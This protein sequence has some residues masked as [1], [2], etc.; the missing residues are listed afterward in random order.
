VTNRSDAVA[1]PIPHAVNALWAQAES[2]RLAS[3]LRRRSIAPVVL[4]GPE[5]QSRLFD[6][7]GAYPSAD[8]DILVH[9]AEATRIDGVLTELGFS[10]HPGNDPWWRVTGHVRYVRSGFVIDVHRNLSRPAV[11]G[12]LLRPLERSLWVD[13]SDPRSGFLEPAIEPLLVLLAVD[14]ASAGWRRPGDLAAIDAAASAVRDWDRVWRIATDCRVVRCLRT[15]LSGGRDDVDRVL[16]GTIGSVVATFGQAMNE[17]APSVAA[18]DLIREYVSYRR[19]GIRLLAPSKI[20]PRVYGHRMEIWEGVCGPG[21]WSR[22]LVD[23]WTGAADGRARPVLVEIGTGSGSLAILAARRRPDADIHATDISFRAWRNARAN[24]RRHGAEVTVH[25]GSL[26][27]ALP[28]RLRHRVQGVVA[29]LPSVWLGGVDEY[30]PD[31]I[32]APRETYEGSGGDGLDLFREL[33]RQAPRWLAAAG[34]VVISMESWQWQVFE[35]EVEPLGYEV[36]SLFRPTESGR[37]IVLRR[38]IPAA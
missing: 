29:H 37:V 20:R 22:T 32:R 21:T 8:T 1:H 38:S 31:E 34:Q 15:G 3:E 35:T 11:P 19:H 26:F 17:S 6:N 23:A 27:D 13:A 4:R 18:Q 36:I 10:F 7:P 25:R 5:L 24:V 12:F 9:R 14:A 30:S 16:D 28:A 2:R 33:L